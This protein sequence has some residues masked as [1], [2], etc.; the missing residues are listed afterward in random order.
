[1]TA[2]LIFRKGKI[3]VRCRRCD[4][5]NG[6]PVE[7][8]QEQA[9]CG[10]C[11]NPLPPIDQPIKL[12]DQNFEEFVR[13]ARPPVLVDFWAPWCGP[14]RMMGPAL[15]SFAKRRSGQVLVA[16]LDTQDNQHVPGQL[17]IQ[18]IPTLIVFRGG[19]EVTRQMGVMHEMLLD[20][21]L[22]FG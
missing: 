8:T 9:S 2:E 13:Q 6:I 16:K 20:K 12:S 7:R 19:R 11:H 21:L 15:E 1:L 3:H 5:I 17:R 14:C 4:R 22:G 10:A 18:S